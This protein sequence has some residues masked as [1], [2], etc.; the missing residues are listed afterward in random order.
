MMGITMNQISKIEY[1]GRAYDSR[2]LENILEKAIGHDSETV[3]V[4]KPESAAIIS[5]DPRKLKFLLDGAAQRGV[6][7]EQIHPGVFIHRN[8]IFTET[9]WAYVVVAMD[10]CGGI[11]AIFDTLRRF[12]MAYPQTPVILVSADFS[13]DDLSCERLPLADVSLKLPL[14]AGRLQ[15]AMEMSL[16]NN[17][18]WQLRVQ[19]LDPDHGE[20]EVSVD[21]DADDLSVAPLDATIDTSSTL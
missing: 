13:K 14:V 9:P 1:K 4:P 2:Y 10:D 17:V 16:L 3:S 7:V 20:G 11:G 6:T 8:D 15:D 18:R 19:L 21:Q 5:R 12:R